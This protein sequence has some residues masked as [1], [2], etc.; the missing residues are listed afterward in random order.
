MNRIA[1]R[2]LLSFTLLAS[3]SQPRVSKSY[4]VTQEEMQAVFQEVKTPYKYGMV[5]VPEEGEMVDDPQVFRYG[6]SWYMVY[7]RFD[8][9]GYETCLAQSSDLLH[10]ERLGVAFQRGREGEWDASQAAGYPILFDTEWGGSNTLRRY[11][12]LYW[13]FYLGGSFDG[14]ETDPLSSGI[15]FTKDPT[16]L[17]SWERYE[18]NPV[19]RSADPD[20]RDFEKKTIYKHFVVEDTSRDL[21]GRF[22]TFYNGKREDVHQESMGIAVSDDMRHWKRVG[23]DPVLCDCLPGQAG[24]SAS[25]MLTRIGDLWVM[26][27][28]G[29]NWKPDTPGAYDNFAC[30]RD[31]VHW[32]SWDGE[33]L[34]KPEE[35]WESTYAHKPWVIKYEGIVYHF[36][37]AVG[38]QGRGIAV[39]TSK[40]LPH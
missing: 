12:G 7:V 24:I 32:K 28:F 22:V 5:L 11:D 3:C 14:Y 1:I 34:I 9:Q 23:S 39:A 30:S 31:L 27:Y 10:W 29:T 26:F 13:M 21:G 15:A 36:Y 33:L 4:P 20:A 6:D 8:N 40:P 37:C 35:P 38:N 25:G 17:L 16:A 2:L 18:G 19:L